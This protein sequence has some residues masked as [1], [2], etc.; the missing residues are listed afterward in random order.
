MPK[1]FLGD[2]FFGGAIQ[3]KEHRPSDG[4]LFLNTEGIVPHR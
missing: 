3:R 4:V 1:G 2:I